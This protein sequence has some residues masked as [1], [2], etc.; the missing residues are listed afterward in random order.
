MRINTQNSGDEGK[1]IVLGGYHFPD[2]TQIFRHHPS[3]PAPHISAAAV[4]PTIPAT[5]YLKYLAA[6]GLCATIT[7]V[8]FLSGS[9]E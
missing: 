6:G 5:G 1:G 3:R 9:S 8:F 2:V 7:H 4:V